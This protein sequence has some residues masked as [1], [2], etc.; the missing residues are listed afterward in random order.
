MTNSELAIAWDGLTH[1]GRVNALGTALAHGVK[2]RM[3]LEGGRGLG[4][5]PEFLTEQATAILK[6]LL[7]A[8][9]AQLAKV[10]Q[11]AAEKAAEMIQPMLKAELTAKVPIFAIMSGLTAGLFTVIGMIL[12][13]KFG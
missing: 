9:G 10:A 6:P 2:V 8:L 11:P 12:I 3:D 7:P 13:K 1:E 4:Q 5:I